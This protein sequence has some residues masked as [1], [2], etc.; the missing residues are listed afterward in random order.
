MALERGP[1]AD[2]TAMPA[3]ELDHAGV[4][5]LRFDRDDAT[6]DHARS[7]PRMRATVGAR[8]IHRGGDTLGPVNAGAAGSSW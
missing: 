1:V 8:A 6:L 3:L 2:V 7:L 5:G 4:L